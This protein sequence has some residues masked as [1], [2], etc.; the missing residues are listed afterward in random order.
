MTRPP[1]LL[2]RTFYFFELSQLIWPD[3]IMSSIRGVLIET[4][5]K[6]FFIFYDRR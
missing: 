1:G 6:V 4:F 3:N 2:T 5:K